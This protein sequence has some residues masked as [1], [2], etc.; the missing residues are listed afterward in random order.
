MNDR[1]EVGLAESGQGGE[2]IESLRSLLDWLMAQFEHSGIDAVWAGLLV[3]L[4]GGLL[5]VFLSWLAYLVAKRVVLRAIRFLSSKTSSDWDNV[6]IEHKVFARLS[7]VVPALVAHVLAPVVFAGMESLVGFVQGLAKVYLVVVVLFTLQ[8]LINGLQT[9]YQRYD[10][11]KRM[12]IKGLL[13][14]AMLV[15]SF[16]G[17]VFIISIVMGREVGTLMA[18]LG[19]MVMGFLFVFKDAIMGLVAGI[20]VATNDT[21]RKGDW[22]EMKDHGIDGDVID[23][24]LTTVK[25]QNFDK[26][27][28]SIPT[29]KLITDACRNWRGMK[30]SGGR[31]IKRPIRI[32]MRS[33]RFADEVLLG[34]FQRFELLGDYL[35]SKLDEVNAHNQRSNTDLSELVNGRRLTNIGTFRAYIMAFLKSHPQIRKDRTFLIRQLAPGDNG[36]PIEIYI[37]TDTTV[38]AE[39][40]AIQADIFDHLLAVIPEFGLAPFQNSTGKESISGTLDVSMVNE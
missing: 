16:V 9:I 6:L 20:Q 31:R 19:A 13:Q 37:F 26:T 3:N 30:D 25:V 21:V 35:Q 4:I 38:W 39:Y 8:A 5:L 7:N 1:N 28:L 27:V 12:P 18:G 17:G 32:D 36:L 23:V 15:A 14:A 22:I 29:S 33:I 11:S 40:E 34:K 24:S 2:T 10:I